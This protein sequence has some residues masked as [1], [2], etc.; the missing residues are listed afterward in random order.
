MSTSR[1]IMCLICIGACCSAVWALPPVQ[2]QAGLS[3]SAAAPE[4]DHHA[5][6]DANQL[7]MFVTNEGSFAHDNAGVM[8]RPDG[9]Y[10]P[11]GS[12]YTW[13][14][15]GGLWLGGYVED[16]LRVSV[17]E[18]TH[19]YTPGP[20]NN[21][22]YQQDNPEFKVY[23]IY[24]GL[25]EDGFYHDPRPATDP[26]AQEQWDDYHNWPAEMGAPTYPD[27][28]PRFLGRQTL[29]SVFNDAEPA[30]HTNDAGS[31]VGLG[32]EVQHTTYAMGATGPLRRCIYNRYLLINKGGTAIDDMHLSLWAD[33]DVGYAFD[34]LIGCDTTMNLG[35]AYNASAMDSIYGAGP[36]AV[37][38]CLLSGPM[39]ASKGDSARFMGEWRR[40]YRNLPMSAFGKYIEEASP[41]N[42]QQSFYYMY[43]LDGSGNYIYNP[44]TYSPTPYMYPGNPVT[45]DGWLDESGT[46]V[47]ESWVDVHEIWSTM[48]GPV[49]PP[50]DVF[51]KTDTTGLWSV[52]TDFPGDR[53]RFDWQNHIGNGIWEFEFG[54]ASSRYYD[55]I[56]GI[57]SVDWAPFN[58]WN[59]GPSLADSTDDMRIQVIYLDDDTTGTWTMGDRIYPFERY[60]WGTMP[61]TLLDFPVD[62]LRIGRIV[63]NGQVPGEIS[64]VQFNAT[65]TT[66][67]V[68]GND[69][70]FLLTSGPFSMAPGDTQE[71]VMV[72]VIGAGL[73]HLQSVSDLKDNAAAARAAW[74]AGFAGPQFVHPPTPACDTTFEVIYGETL[75]F[76]IEA[77][78]ATIEDQVTLS[79]LDLPLGA[80]FSQP[81]PHTD[82]PVATTFFW[83]PSASQLG[84]HVVTFGVI[85][86][87]TGFTEQCSFE[88]IVIAPATPPKFAHPP[89]PACDTTY[90]LQPGDTLEIMVEADD[91]NTVDYVTLTV[92]GVPT[93]AT[94]LPDLPLKGNPV[95]TKLMWLPDYANLG[96]DTVTFT[97]YDSTDGLS[98]Q[99]KFYLQVTSQG[100]GPE[101][102]HP[103]TPPCDTI[104][105]VIAGESFSMSVEI[106]D[107]VAADQVTL[108]GSGLPD[109]MVS[110]NP[111]P[112]TGNPVSTTL[113]WQPDYS[114]LG[115]D[116]IMFTAVDS[117]DGMFAFCSFVIDVISAGLPP[118]FAH[119]PTPG[120]DTTFTVE[121]GD[122]ICFEVEAFD[123]I[124]ADQVTLTATGLPPGATVTPTLPVKGN[125]TSVSVCWWPDYSELGEYP[126]VFTATDSIDNLGS[127]CAFVVEV[128]PAEIA[129]QFQHPP[130]PACD[131][132]FAVEVGDTLRFS[133]R[134]F[135]EIDVETVTLTVEA[136]PAGA[137]LNPSLPTSGNPVGTA[138]FWVPTANDLGLHS[139]LFVA[140][141]LLNG[142]AVQCRIEVDVSQEVL[143]I[144]GTYPTDTLM[145]DDRFQVTLNYPVDPT[146]VDAHAQP[147]TAD[148]NVIAGTYAF[149]DD[150]RTIVFK[151]AE[152]FPPLREIHADL[153]EIVGAEG[154]PWPEDNLPVI[155]SWQTGYGVHPGD[156]NNDGVVDSLDVI[157]IAAHWRVSGPARLDADVW[158]T[159]NMQAANSWPIPGATYADADGN[160]IV[161][162][163]DLFPIGR[164]W[165]QVH[166][167]PST[168]VGT[169]MDFNPNDYREELLAFYD[170]IR[171]ND[172]PFMQKIRRQL[173]QLLGFSGVPYEFY[174]AQ[175]H[176]NPFNS[177]TA[178]VFS[179]PQ[180]DRIKLTVF[181]ALGRPVRVLAQGQ[182]PAGVNTVLWDGCDELGF[183]VA[184]G[185]YFYTLTVKLRSETRKMMLLK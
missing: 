2:R 172:S 4:I 32:V 6:I 72:V 182:F 17:A 94:L 25:Y 176:P 127:Q 37:G 111:L 150:N 141:D 73:N 41:A 155:V 170:A 143:Q 83:T 8:G 142:L 153:S 60:Y 93:G 35:Y 75:S 84:P 79:V 117:I 14:Y 29:W 40:E 140:T 30:K 15:A 163:T 160:G 107:D 167:Y 86:E 11:K 130:T 174:L 96:A 145:I 81:L 71:V 36:P 154:Q 144:E 64:V 20:M 178:I 165:K 162:E 116:T 152:F 179:L 21:G 183:R 46:F 129:P 181:D 19:T 112:A 131:T 122:S 106:F 100:I 18:Y 45:G 76:D 109:G 89:T 34:D 33:P 7:L 62:E 158:P 132:V 168:A 39:V 180:A 108:R 31:A 119:P 16:N 124:T 105:E 135:D 49:N 44:Y 12:D 57:L 102:A 59:R 121:A 123:E 48:I 23:K 85:D 26:V 125:P 114:Q 38:I 136:L 169:G 113:F 98:A 161:D 5:F 9:L 95:S 156:L 118:G 74:F 66:E 148:G 13:M 67:F 133:V 175:N 58:V 137:Q 68:P 22:T 139:M 134:A 110:S 77:S 65:E 164:H 138:F 151:P 103:P 157:P 115:S 128:V 47:R 146:T 70:R 126:I 149:E 24:R 10:F 3:R 147:A 56:T 184:S 54:G 99:C 104:F 51:E 92:T 82:N 52:S 50:R 120:C 42:A 88:I 159:W 97:A 63:F 43:G 27:G 55:G 87:N 1:W 61:D 185:M 101:F 28:R 171:G 173:E 80:T 177:A 166:N 69:G 91:D 53:S 78:D 90:T